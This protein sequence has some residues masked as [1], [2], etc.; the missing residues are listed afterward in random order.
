MVHLDG[1]QEKFA[2]KGLKVLAITNESRSAVDEFVTKT[3]AKHGIVIESGD[4]A[5]AFE[6]KSYPSAFLIGPDGRI[7]WS[8]HPGR[9]DEALMARAISLVRVAPE[10]PSALASITPSLEKEKWAEA[11]AKTQKLIDG[12]TL[13]TDEDKEAAAKLVTWIDW[14]A[15][16][17]VDSAKA[18]GAKGRWYEAVALLEGVKRDFK[19]LP[20]ALEADTQL[21]AISADKAKKDDVT[22]YGKLLKAKATQREKDMKPKE[23]L[24]LFKSIASKYVDTRAG[25]AAAEIAKQLEIDAGK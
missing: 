15:Q 3:S 2:A 16:S 13:T 11:R 9:A 6:V 5:E 21:K 22:S 1:L 8:G 24:P 14:L 18:E 20:Q 10:L 17:G 7:L 12:G 23:A 25:K 4:S 19:G